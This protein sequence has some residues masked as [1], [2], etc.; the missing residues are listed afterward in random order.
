MD[1]TKYAYPVVTYLLN[2]VGN[3]QASRN[4]I[5][6]TFNTLTASYLIFKEFLLVSKRFD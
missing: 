5:A 1:K 4:H 2:A 3:L 6:S